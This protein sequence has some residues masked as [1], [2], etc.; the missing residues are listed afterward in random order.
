MPNQ[1]ALLLLSFFSL[2]AVIYF[3]VRS[4]SDWRARRFGWAVT[5]TILAALGVVTM[6]TP[7]ETHAVKID[8]PRN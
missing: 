4:V 1:L 3:F 2:A 7:M 5:G 6:L 8:L